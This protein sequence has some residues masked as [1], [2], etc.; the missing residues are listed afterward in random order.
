MRHDLVALLRD[1]NPD[2][3]IDAMLELM[4]TDPASVESEAPRLL[5]WLRSGD[6]W[7]PVTAVW[8]LTRMRR[9][10][11]IPHLQR[12][13]A[14]PAH[15]WHATEARLAR[16]LLQGNED[17][18]WSMLRNHTHELTQHLAKAAYMWR[19]EAA[20]AALVACQESAPDA[21]CRNTC[22]RSLTKL[23]DTH[24]D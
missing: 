14:E 22:A 11:A 23:A 7:K 24:G 21:E 20:R 6:Y 1:R 4:E 10:D 9:L 3:A 2:V 5:R 16:M 15:Y 8:I 18:V 17:E 13:E 12:L 19:S